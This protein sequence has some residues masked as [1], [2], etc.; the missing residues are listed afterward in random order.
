[1]TEV[2]KGLPD[3]NFDEH[4]GYTSTS[5]PYPRQRGTLRHSLTRDI[6]V[7]RRAGIRR[8]CTYAEE[9]D[10]AANKVSQR[11]RSGIHAMFSG[12]YVTRTDSSLPD[13]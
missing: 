5:T 9:A 2:D 1:V 6:Q 11:K 4:Y 13:R 3:C 8:I 7:M 10:D 12:N